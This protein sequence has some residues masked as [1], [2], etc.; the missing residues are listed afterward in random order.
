MALTA[1]AV[2]A[3][4]AAGPA[5]ASGHPAQPPKSATPGAPGGEAKKAPPA[6]MSTLGGDQLGRPGDQLGVGAPALPPD[7]SALSWMVTDADTGQVLGARNAHWQLP[8]PAP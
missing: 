3:G 7:L 4:A 5:V 2:A 1:T 8:R 6:H